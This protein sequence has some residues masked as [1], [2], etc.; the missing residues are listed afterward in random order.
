M[1]PFLKNWL[2]AAAVLSLLTAP[3]IA[4]SDPMTGRQIMEQVNARDDGVTLQRRFVLELTNRD[5]R[6]RTEQ[7]RSF[8]RYFGDEKRTVIF[9]EEPTRVRGT[10]FLTYD[11]AD[12]SVDDDQW[13]Y[14]PA[15]RKVRRISASDRGDFF[16]GTD[17]TYEDIKK[18]QK[19]EV[20]DYAFQAK[21]SENVG[22]IEALIV[23][24]TPISEHISEELGYSRVVWRVDPGIWMSRR[25]DLYDLNG[26]HLKTIT[27][28]TVETIDGITTATEILAVNRK[29]GHSTRLTFSEVDYASDVPESLFTQARLRRG[30]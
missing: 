1:Q 8:R 14:L 5:G 2:S 17:F 7:T 6:T 21:G 28:E 4:E 25:T 18:E 10:G 22:G 30:L 27:L 16:L 20:N 23:E 26:N 13:L 15:L 3:A 19:V 24:G 9:Y 11:Y 12:V 29:T